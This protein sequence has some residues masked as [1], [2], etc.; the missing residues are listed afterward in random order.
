MSDDHTV[1]IELAQLKEQM[2]AIGGNVSDIKDALSA[3][4]SLDKTIAEVVIH[5]K[6]TQDNVQLLWKRHDESQAW[7]LAHER[8]VAVVRKDISASMERIRDEVSDDIL[9]TD[10]KVET[11]INQA[12]GA[13]WAAGIILGVVQIV[14][15]AGIT[16][17]F[18]NVTALR[19]QGSLYG[20]RIERLETRPSTKVEITNNEAARGKSNE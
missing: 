16:W 14:V 10:R 13:S 9:T 17:T 15:I 20:L 19:E 4:T 18:T 3:L 8:E 1:A 2:K 12:K 11:W 7:Q 5:H 6:Q